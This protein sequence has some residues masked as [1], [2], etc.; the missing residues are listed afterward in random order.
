[1]ATLRGLLDD[2]R[3]L[4]STSYKML[5]ELSR[6]METFARNEIGTR[7]DTNFH[8]VDVDV[9]SNADHYIVQAD[10]PGFT[11]DDIQIDIT[12]AGLMRLSAERKFEKLGE[13]GSYMRKYGSFVKELK[14]PD[15]CNMDHIKARMDNGVLT[16]SVQKQNVKPNVRRIQLSD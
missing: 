5:G 9:M 11:K 13:T 8:V 14:L 10:F 1:M 12:D 2:F 16:V 6:E 7:S 15:D 3:P 4:I